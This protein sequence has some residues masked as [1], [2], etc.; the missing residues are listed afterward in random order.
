MTHQQRT[1][2]GCRQREARSA[3][4][5]VVARDGSA[6]VDTAACLP[7]RGAWLHPSQQCLNRIDRRVLSRQLRTQITDVSGLEIRFASDCSTERTPIEKAGRKP[8]GTR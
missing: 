8:M 2:I 5:R 7:G 3:L 1:C 6:I 4:V